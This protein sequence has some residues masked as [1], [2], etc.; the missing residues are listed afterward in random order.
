MSQI[1]DYLY[2]GSLND[3]NN[4]EFIINNKIKTIINVTYNHENIKYN[5]IKYYKIE[6][7]D[8]EKQPIIYVI[9]NVINII[10][11]N[12]NNGNILVHCYVGK[13]RS[14]TCVIA[15]LMK[16]YN[17][18]LEKA[19][20]YIKDKRYIINPNHGFINQLMIFEKYINKKVDVILYLYIIII[21]VIFTY[22]IIYKKN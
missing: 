2:L 19:F 6:T 15:Y 8:N 10:N 3:S 17:M 5:N 22:K 7:L 1:K 21:I 18:T 14:A 13:S 4:E 12:K 11:E 16:E 20:I 9:N